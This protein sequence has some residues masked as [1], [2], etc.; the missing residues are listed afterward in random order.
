MMAKCS[1]H[2]EGTVR[3]EPI[4]LPL[5]NYAPEEDNWWATLRTRWT[6]A[7]RHSLG[8]SEIVYVIPTM[9]LGMLEIPTVS[10]KLL[11]FFRMLPLTYKF[12][13]VHWFVATLAV[14]PFLAG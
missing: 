9:Y 13:G 6:Q 14:W 10:R 4:F 12:I 1:L 5:M 2:S 11:Y 3:C 8:I 7:C